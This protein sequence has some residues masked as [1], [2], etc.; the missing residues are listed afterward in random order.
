MLFCYAFY[1][2]IKYSWKWF[3]A[4]KSVEMVVETETSIIAYESSNVSYWNRFSF[5]LCSPVV[6]IVC[7]LLAFF[8]SISFGNRFIGIHKNIS[9]SLAL[10][11]SLALSFPRS[12][13][14][15]IEANKISFSSKT[16]NIHSQNGYYL[17]AYGKIDNVKASFVG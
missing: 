11:L 9:F 12:L 3:I 7:F 6:T 16:D 14:C 4:D 5:V 1:Q 15:S 17:W 2:I 8:S 10:S 13:F